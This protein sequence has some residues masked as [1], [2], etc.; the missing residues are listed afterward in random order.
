M[1]NRPSTPYCQISG[2]QPWSP[3][4]LGSLARIRFAFPEAHERPTNERFTAACVT[5]NPRGSDPR[6]LDDDPPVGPWFSFGEPT[7]TTAAVDV[8][9]SWSGDWPTVHWIWDGDQYLRFN[10][11]HKHLWVDQEG[12]GERSADTLVVLTARRYTASQ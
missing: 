9:L 2:A 1:A 7:P 6:G 11:D 5:E 8:A 12:E 3:F 10:G 4:V